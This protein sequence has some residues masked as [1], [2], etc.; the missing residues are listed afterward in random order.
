MLSSF[1]KGLD[2]AKIAESMRHRGVAGTVSHAV[3]RA[4]TALESA[5]TG[6]Y[7]IRVNPMGFVCNHKCPMCWLQHLDP[8]E[9]E[10]QKKAD[11]DEGMKL[12]EYVRL[13]DGMTAGLLEVNFVG[14]GEPLVHPQ[15]PEIM[16]EV[17]RRGWRGTLIS[18]GSLLKESTAR[19]LVDMDWDSTRIS[20]HA[21][22]AATYRE[23]QGVDRYDTVLRNLK[24]FDAMRREAG[25][26]DRVR[27]QVFHVI[28]RA[29]IASID[30]LFAFAEEVGAD[31]VEFD[32]IIPYDD[33]KFLTPEEFARA[34]EALS[35]G[36]RDCRIPTNIAE[37]LPQ[38]QVQEQLAAESKPFVPGK[39]CS[40]GFDQA[41][42][43]SFGDVTPCCFS[44]EVMGN[45]RE[46]TF[47]EIWYG[48]RFEEFRKRLI[49]G[50]FAGYC[51]SNRC[52]LPLVIHH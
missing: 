45:L 21:G 33:D 4:G 37:I 10:K 31:S 5:L 8:A 24:A 50:K 32:P 35:A 15:C 48:E 52:T 22:D 51:I 25:K 1:A 7:L 14:G 40:V 9:L 44:S 16:R 49:R 26:Q 23:I 27:L 42:I 46:Q 34:R 41:F 6:P 43:N 38:L 30:R 47:A 29:N 28:Q 11:R 39:K 12:E 36:A 20:V 13:F 18:N 3:R 17:R 19:A 2:P